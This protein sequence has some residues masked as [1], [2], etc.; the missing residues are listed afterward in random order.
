MPARLGV[1]IIVQTGRNQI[2]DKMA[3]FEL[4]AGDYVVKPVERRELD[5][6]LQ[7]VMRRSDAGAASGKN[8]SS[9]MHVIRRGVIPECLGICNCWLGSD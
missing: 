3:C 9:A 5:M 4:G 7:A 2:E 1:P 6:P 8:S